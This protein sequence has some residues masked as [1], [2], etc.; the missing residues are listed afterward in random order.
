M[1]KLRD[2]VIDVEEYLAMG[3]DVESI[4]T[5]LDIPVDIV[6]TVMKEEDYHET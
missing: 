1:S 4:A 5:I 2:L 6:L 3:Y